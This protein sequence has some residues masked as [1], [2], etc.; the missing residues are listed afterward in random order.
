[1][2]QHH[3]FTRDEIRDKLLQFWPDS[4]ELQLDKEIKRI[5]KHMPVY[6]IEDELHIKIHYKS[7]KHR[8]YKRNKK[9]KVANYDRCEESPRVNRNRNPGIGHRDFTDSM[10]LKDG[11][12]DVKYTGEF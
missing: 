8:P 4:T 11:V 2:S 1:M 12:Y 9:S 6:V 5:H 10:D 3:L 7:K